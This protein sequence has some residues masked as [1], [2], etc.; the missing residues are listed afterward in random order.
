MIFAY[1]FVS[2]N[3]KISEKASLAEDRKVLLLHLLKHKLNH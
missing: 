3:F 1:N 2:E